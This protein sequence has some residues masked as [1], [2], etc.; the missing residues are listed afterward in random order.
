MTVLVLALVV[1]VWLAPPV[2]PF[3][4]GPAGPMV[5]QGALAVALNDRLTSSAT[6]AAKPV[7]IG[8][9]FR[10]A[11]G[12]LCRTFQ[13]GQGEG[14]AGVACREAQGWVVRA[15]ITSPIPAATASGRTAG[16]DIPAPLLYVVQG[17]I[18]GRPLDVRAEAA[19]RAADWRP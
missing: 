13:L 5:A 3:A 7:S 11:A 16:P 2:P 17:M 14:L 1:R 12:P 8:V 15:A 4:V 19:A 6:G 9:S 18:Q 10:S